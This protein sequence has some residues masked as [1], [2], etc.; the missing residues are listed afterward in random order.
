MQVV[1]LTNVA[2]RILDRV[3]LGFHDVRNCRVG[4]VLILH[5]TLQLQIL[6]IET[7]LRFLHLFGRL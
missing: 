1:D 7:H 4:A 2:N 3:M 6:Q 5:L